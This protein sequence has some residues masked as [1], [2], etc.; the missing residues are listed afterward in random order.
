MSMTAFFAGVRLRN[1]DEHKVTVQAV[2]VISH[3]ERRVFPD[4]I[5]PQFA[6]ESREAPGHTDRRRHGAFSVQW[7]LVETRL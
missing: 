5:H 1:T 4:S 6:R 7:I 3:C 2:T